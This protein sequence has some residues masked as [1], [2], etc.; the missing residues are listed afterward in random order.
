M[1][2]EKTIEERIKNRFDSV[3]KTA[4]RVVGS[5]QTESQLVNAYTWAVDVVLSLS[6]LVERT[7][8]PAAARF[9]HTYKGYIINQVRNLYKQRQGDVR[10]IPEIPAGKI[11]IREVEPHISVCRTCNGKG[12]TA[13]VSGRKCP[14]CHG[15]GRVKISS[16]VKS[17][18]QPYDPEKEDAR[19]AVGMD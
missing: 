4:L 14:S 10:A 6:D 9:A 19:F 15:S 16:T 2:N 17:L 7:E 11:T 5:C 1:N 8:S 18:I 3:L 12:K 13:H